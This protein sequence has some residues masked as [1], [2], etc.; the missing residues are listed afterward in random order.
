MIK[1]ISAFILSLTLAVGCFASCDDKDSKKDDSSKTSSSSASKD[2]S[3]TDSNS[4]AD[5]SSQ[6]EV[7]EPSLTIDG[8]K[9]D[10]KNYTMCTIDGEKIDFDTFRYFYYYTL[11]TY[12]QYGITMDSINGTDGGFKNF[13]KEVKANISND[14]VSKKL[15][16]EEGIE[17]DDDDQKEIDKS[18][19]ELKSNLKVTT[20]KEYKNQLKQMY[21]TEDLVKTM[22]T[23]EQYYQKLFGTGGKYVTSKEDLKK[24]VKDNK[25]Y[26]R[27]IHILIPYEC[28]AEITDSSDLESYK[29]A[30][31]SAKLNAKKTA[32]NALDEK[33]QKKVKE[34]SK[35][36]AEE[37]LAKAK[38]GD[39]F[40]KLMKE[41]G[42]D[43]GMESQPEGY[44]VNQNTSFVEEFK[45]AAF[46]LKEN[47]ISGL[48]E[49]EN[50]G[51]FIIKRL[52]VDMDYVEKNYNDMVSEYD[53]SRFSEIFQETVAKMKV[54]DSKDFSKI[55]ADSIK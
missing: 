11:Q 47:E 19:S 53:N 35:K 38:K 55:T 4:S 41:Y 27:V 36:L 22:F 54:E 46:K 13:M 6:A 30:D 25:Q 26:S 23:H 51:W 52:P 8:K 31:L 44:Y 45:T 32:Y 50:Y 29:D 21:M 1:K 28:Q 40:E 15:C 33:G 34:K 37:V 2:E 43:P 24:A 10:T 17:L 18:I 7:P 49:N 16:K 42:W 20:D 12:S 14:L 5:A 39:D 3:K 48:V 9:I